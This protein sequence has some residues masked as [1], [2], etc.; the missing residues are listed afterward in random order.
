MGRGRDGVPKVEGEG[1]ENG[2]REGPGRQRASQ[3]LEA[4]GGAR[5]RWAG[6]E[7]VRSWGRGGHGGHRDRAGRGVV[8][9]GSWEPAC[10][11]WTQKGANP[12]G[13]LAE[14]CSNKEAQTPSGW[15]GRSRED[16]AV[17]GEDPVGGGTGPWKVPLGRRGW[18]SV[19]MWPGGT[20]KQAPASTDQRAGEGASGLPLRLC[21][22]RSSLP[23]PSRGGHLLRRAV[24]SRSRRWDQGPARPH[25]SLLDSGGTWLVSGPRPRS[26]EAACSG[27]WAVEVRGPGHPHF[28]LGGG[29]PARGS[30]TDAG[31]GG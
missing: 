16:R 17:D 21:P 11:G 19:S 15:G 6:Q 9:F 12:E 13:S 27:T 10:P 7:A 30:N 22:Y 14:F 18:G 4:N 23:G 31:P 25:H 1:S 3:D 24:H 20:R 29:A 26:T 28:P 8:V 5:G 2:R